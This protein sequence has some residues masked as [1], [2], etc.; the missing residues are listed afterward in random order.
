[1]QRLVQRT[2]RH[3]RAFAQQQ[4]VGPAGW[5]LLDVVGHEHDGGVAGS[6]GEVAE[7]SRPGPPGR[8]GRGRPW[9]RRAA[10]ARVR[11][12]ASGPA[13]PAA[14]RPTTACRTALGEVVDA[15][16][17]EHRRRPGPVVVVVGVPPRLEGGVLRG[18]HGVEHGEVGPQQVGERLAG[19]ARCG[20]AACARRC[21]RAAR[22][23]PRTRPGTGA[24]T[25]R[26]CAAA[27]SCRPVGA[28]HDP[29]LSGWTVQS[30]PSRIVRPS[31]AS[32]TSCSTNVGSITRSS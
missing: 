5:D 14:A 23:A 1:M 10:A 31:R 13:A 16:P 22:R 11:R 28:E 3:D 9:A 6:C 21:A 20:S 18:H 19:R 29:A 17:V 2:G 8:R 7:A 25:A 32:R 24:A 12:R 30:T 4:G 27:S 26:R 15:H